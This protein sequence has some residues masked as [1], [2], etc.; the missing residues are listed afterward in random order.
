MSQSPLAPSRSSWRRRRVPMVMIAAGTALLPVTLAMVPGAASASSH[1]EAP[2]IATDP[3]ADNTDFYAFVSPDKADTV[4]F[5]A[6]WLPLQEPNGGP[7][8]YPWATDTHHD[9]NIDND[10]DGRPDIT[11]RWDFRTEDRRGAAQTFLYNIGPVTSLN[12]DDLLFRQTYTLTEIRNGRSTVLLRDAPVAPSNVGPGSMPD[13]GKL[14][15]EAVVGVGSGGKSFVGQADDAFFLDLR[16]FD[17]LYGGNLTEIG[18]DTVAGYNVNTIALQVPVT[19]LV[20]RGDSARNPVIGTWSATSRRSL[21]LSPGRATPTGDYVQVSRLAMPLTNEVILPANLK[22]TFNAIPPEADLTVPGFLDRVLDPEV[23]RLVE[24]IYGIPAPA[25]PRHDLVELF[26]TGI[27]KNAPMPDGSPAPIQTDLNSQILNA[28]VNPAKFVPSDQLRLNTAVP[29]AT[30]P[31]RLGLLAGDRQGFPNGRRLA[32][33]VVDIEV[34][35]FEGA[36][37]T[38]L[39]N[40]LIAGDAVPFN[41]VPFGATFPYVALPHNRSVN[42]TIR[43]PGGA[44]PPQAN[45]GG[46]VPPVAGGGWGGGSGSLPMALVTGLPALVLLGSGGVLLVRRRGTVVAAS[47]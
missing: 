13:Y 41:D 20:L 21:Q 4:T 45:L 16:V 15:R 36:A 34:L 30:L 42:S 22:D 1:R 14:R 39:V 23:P 6:N 9:I 19:D 32:D 46:A 29:P 35:Y 38:G 11:Y 17:L 47:A 40:P 43:L 31:N 37:K 5:V 25:T 12:D 28:D 10:G 27:A 24:R 2:L 44:I 33:D 3:Q 8:F 7:T 26:L 18:Q